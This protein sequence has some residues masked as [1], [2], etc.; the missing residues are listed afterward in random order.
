MP[1]LETLRSD[2]EEEDED[3]EDDEE[4][5]EEFDSDGEEAAM[6]SQSSGHR[7]P[8]RSKNSSSSSRSTRLT[9]TRAGAERK[10]S[11]KNLLLLLLPLLFHQPGST[12]NLL[13]VWFSREQSRGE[14]PQWQIVTRCPALPAG[15]GRSVVSRAGRRRRHAAPAQEKDG[16]SGREQDQ[17]PG[18]VGRGLRGGEAADEEQ[19]PPAAHGEERQARSCDPKQLGVGPGAVDAE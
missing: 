6:S 7:Y 11:G 19:Q 1:V 3:E 13:R 5:E 15:L 16:E 4:E 2:S 17:A 9:R 14:W 18:G 12:L 8:S 10:R